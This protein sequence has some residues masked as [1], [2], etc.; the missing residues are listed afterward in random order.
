MGSGSASMLGAIAC[1]SVWAALLTV[2]FA[3]E[4]EYSFSAA[5]THAAQ[6][7]QPRPGG[8]ARSVGSP[9][10]AEPML[11]SSKLG[12]LASPP[13]SRLPKME[14]KKPML[15]GWIRTGKWPASVAM[16][17]LAGC[18][19]H[20]KGRVGL[21][22]LGCMESCHAM[23]LA[24]QWRAHAHEMLLPPS[25]HTLHTGQRKAAHPEHHASPSD[26]RLTQPS[27]YIA[28]RP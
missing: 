26:Q 27:S 5:H 13:P 1:F 11:K 24:M 6:R 17:Q 19:M 25:S 14:L 2:S 23:E 21:R 7:V 4:L 20:N 18:S 15:A 10:F 28:I 12:D 22:E 3:D 9:S 8:C 16:W